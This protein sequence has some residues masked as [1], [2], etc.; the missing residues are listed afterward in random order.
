MINFVGTT[1][2]I[3]KM[4][5]IGNWIMPQ[6]PTKQARPMP[7]PASANEPPP[8]D[9]QKSPQ[10]DDKPRK[11]RQRKANVVPKKIDKKKRQPK[12]SNQKKRKSVQT[13]VKA[14]KGGQKSKPKKQPT[15]K[16]DSQIGKKN[17]KKP[18]PENAENLHEEMPTNPLAASA[19]ERPPE[20]EED[21]MTV[22]P[23]PASTYEPP[24]VDEDFHE[25]ITDDALPAGAYETLPKNDYNFPQKSRKRRLKEDDTEAEKIGQKQLEPIEKKQVPLKIKEMSIDEKS[26]SKGRLKKKPKWMTDLFTEKK[27]NRSNSKTC[28]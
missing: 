19:Y 12:A 18:P 9:E 6:I 21:E 20:D 13:T 14:I 10:Q 11:R 4:T 17:E 27:I 23:L 22:N 15:R 3:Q 8:Q 7:P 16:T 5:A 25:K 28:N 1:N 26:S 2:S 24:P